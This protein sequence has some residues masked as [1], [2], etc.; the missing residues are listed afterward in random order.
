VSKFETNYSQACQLLQKGGAIRCRDLIA[1]L[2][3]LG[4]RIKDAASGNHKT[5]NH[6]GL[7]DF[8]GA[9]FN[10]GHGKNSELKPNYPRTV[11][12]ILEKYEAELIEWNRKQDA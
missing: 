4:F 10:C 8:H 5:F 9:S 1:K 11:L 2:E 3:S 12:K 6:P 7:P